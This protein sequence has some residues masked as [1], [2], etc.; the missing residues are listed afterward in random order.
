[1]KGG[2]V[3]SRKALSSRPVLLPSGMGLIS[4]LF[5]VV[6]PEALPPFASESD[7]TTIE[8]VTC[9]VPND[10]ECFQFLAN[11]KKW[12]AWKVTESVFFKFGS[13]RGMGSNP[14]P[15]Y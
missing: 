2:R 8:S 9:R 5:A 3:E 12:K 14:V 10:G 6:D 7:K 1:M 11:R 13:E 4:T 15:G